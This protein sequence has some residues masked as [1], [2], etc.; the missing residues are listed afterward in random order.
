MCST[1]LRAVFGEMTR[2][3]A[4]SLVERPRATH[5]DLARRQSG[6]PFA[7]TDTPVPGSAEHGLCRSPVQ[8]ARPHF[9]TKDSGG[10][11]GRARRSVR[12]RLGECRIDIRNRDESRRWSQ[13]RGREPVRV[14]GAVE[15]LVMPSRNGAD[16]SERV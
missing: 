11:V 10:G 1:W 7:P 13:R 14:T 5:L 16:R 9:A 12:T 8:P 2:C 4:I 3:A 15:T 6:R